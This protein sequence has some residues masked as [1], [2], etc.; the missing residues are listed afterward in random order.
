MP[1]RIAK[2]FFYDVE[3]WLFAADRK[4]KEVRN[5]MDEAEMATK[6]CL[7]GLCPNVKSRYQLGKKADL[8]AMAIA[9]LPGEVRFFGRVSYRTAPEPITFEPARD[10]KA[11]QSRDFVLNE[12]MDALKDDSVI[13][14]GVHGVS[15][16]GKTTLVKEVARRAMEGELF[17]SA[18]MAVVTQT[19]DI[20]KIQDQI[21]DELALRFEEKSMAVRA[22][23][24]C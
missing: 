6:K 17:D 16:V 2:R 21:A 7:I 24:L 1:K 22:S 18:C 5:L 14:I 3:A 8:E 20:K 19:P 12:I 10:F 11:F 23:Q 4:I 15:G 13:V 9:E